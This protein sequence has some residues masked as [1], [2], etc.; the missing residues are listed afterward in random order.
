MRMSLKLLLKSAILLLSVLLCSHYLFSPEFKRSSPIEKSRFAVA[1]TGSEHLRLLAAEALPKDLLLVADP[2]W[3]GSSFIIVGMRGHCASM[4][5]SGE[6]LFAAEIDPVTMEVTPY[7]EN[8]APSARKEPILALVD[9]ELVIWGGVQEIRDSS[10]EKQDFSALV[11]DAEAALPPMYESLSEVV[12]YNRAEQIWKT[13]PLESIISSEVESVASERHANGGLWSGKGALQSERKLFVWQTETRPMPKTYLG[14]YAIDIDVWKANALSPVSTEYVTSRDFSQVWSTR[15][16]VGYFPYRVMSSDILESNAE[17]V[18]RIKHQ[19]LEQLS[20]PGNLADIDP[21]CEV[22]EELNLNR[23]SGFVYNLA[24]D[25]WKTIDPQ[26]APSP[27]LGPVVQLLDNKLLVW[28]GFLPVETE[29]D[30][31]RYG[32]ALADGAIYDLD[33]DSWT[34]ISS[35]GA[36]PK[37]LNVASKVGGE[38]LVYY[39]KDQNGSDN[40]EPSVKE[41][42]TKSDPALYLYSPGTNSWR[43]LSRSN[44]RGAKTFE[45]VDNLYL[46]VIEESESSVGRAFAWYDPERETATLIDPETVERFDW[47]GY[48]VGGTHI[49]IWQV[50]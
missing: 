34:P 38:L 32:D 33:T 3:T 49:L 50:G 9:G 14:P 15:Y 7:T 31:L 19:C 10:C 23:H 27:R 20:E 39:F 29:G 2:I 41:A 1:T 37:E 18:E 40:Y 30:E 28:G 12:R 4:K 48:S 36:P 44:L 11:T 5:G 8:N 22:P 42:E 25:N 6:F 43:K 45:K 35:K 26:G 16:F 21:V 24:S 47:P 46:V 13:A 17:E